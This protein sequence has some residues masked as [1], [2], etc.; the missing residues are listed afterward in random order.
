MTSEAA[1]TATD[2]PAEIST[3]SPSSSTR[4]GIRAALTIPVIVAALGYFVDMYDLVLF[5]VVRK[6]S[7]NAIGITSA[8]DVLHHGMF[9]MNMQM[10][11]MLIGGIC[12]GIMGDKIGR[13]KML[14]GSILIYSTANL[15]NAWVGNVE[16]YAIL[17]F[18][19]GFGLAGELG[20]GITLVVESLPTHLR[21]YG[22]MFVAGIGVAGAASS[23]LVYE[24]VG[25]SNSFIVGGLMGFSLLFMLFFSHES[26]VFSETAG[27]R[28]TRGRFFSLFTDRSRFT[29]YL[30]CI[31]IGVPI[32]FVVGML[33]MLAE[34]IATAVGVVGP[35][36]NGKAVM[37]CFIG[38]IFG[39][40]ASCLV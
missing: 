4:A 30:T 2:L 25:W 9:L 35:I 31:A 16:Q 33:V 20:V 40:F 27:A 37:W 3:T 1:I 18:I 28:S 26:K 6:D 24:L 34:E 12:W 14:F 29:R 13:L 21:G 17:R 38:L 32:W 15:L 8:A 5:G 19:A 7:L 36:S 10:I 39:D 22:T 11:G 23:Y